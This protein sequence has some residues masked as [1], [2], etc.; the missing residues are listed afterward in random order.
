MSLDWLP[1]DDEVKNHALWGKEH[2]G[3][4]PPCV[5]Y[6]K[7]PV[8]DS[9]GNEVKG[10]YS[11]WVILNNPKQYN[12][13]TTEMVKGVI[14]GFQ[15]ASLDRSVVSVVFTAVGDRAFCT[16]GNTKEYAEYYSK[17]PNEYG[18]Y[19]DL[20]NQM[21]DAIL[22]CKKPTICRVN[23]MRIAGGQEIGMACDIAIAADTATFGQAGPRHGSAPDGG[24]S[25]FLP[26]YLSIEDALW[27]CVSCEIWSAYKMKRLGLITRVVPVIKDG[28]KWIRN[29]MVITGKYVEDGEIVYGELVKGE[30]LK[31]A[32]EFL[33]GGKKD[34]GLLDAAVNEVIWKFV[35]LMP[36]CL[37]KSIDGVRMKKKFFWDVAKLAN[38]HWLAANMSTE[39]FLGFHAFNTKKITGKDVID[40]V[41]YR[42]LIAEGHVFD[43]SLAEEVFGK[44]K[45]EAE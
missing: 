21:V 3:T 29:P 40:F 18:E 37:I 17:R 6:E 45:P 24:S 19:M 33:K 14:A 44:P 23:G 15:N 41:K 4:E 28:E 10:L 31:K 39:A 9:D 27:N 26:W 7:R 13:Y 22:M 2:F 36:G 11:A 30:E 38:R 20:F 43:D 16:G 32:K 5:I 8:I 12:S 35:N 34:F 42:Q 25:D 1:R